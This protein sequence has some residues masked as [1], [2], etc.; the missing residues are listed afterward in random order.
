MDSDAKEFVAACTTC[1]RSK[2]SNQAPAG[3]LRPLRPLPVPGRPWSHIALDFV[4]GLPPSSGKTHRF[5]KAAHF[6]AL[7]KL[8]SAFTTA[9][10]L[11][12]HVFRLHGIPMDIV[13]DRGPQFISQVG[14]ALGAMASLSSGYHPQTNGQ[15][16]RANQILETSLCCMVEKEPDSWSILLPWISIPTTA[17]PAHR[18]VELHLKFLL[19]IN[20]LC[21][22]L[23]S[24][25][26]QFLQ[27][28]TTWIAAK[29]SGQRLRPPSNAPRRIIDGLLTGTG[30]KRL[31]ISQVS[32]SG[33]P[34]RTF[35]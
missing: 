31:P 33:S 17:S 27:Y 3:P 29:R 11:V 25:T 21:S 6:I 22:L 5:S 15:S 4:T 10:L 7:P 18:L 32:L 34:P 14:K 9:E 24:K 1:A 28:R 30:I 26:S 20:H 19:A 12:M 16:E 13:S 8:P 23:T 2:A 35:L